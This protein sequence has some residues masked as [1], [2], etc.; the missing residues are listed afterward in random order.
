MSE[1]VPCK[2]PECSN[3]V[4]ASTAELN[5]GL[6]MICVRVVDQE[7]R[8]RY[9]R[10]HRRDVNEFEGV[11]DPVEALRIIHRPRGFDPLVNWIPN[12]TP[13][14]QL[15]AGLNRLDQ[16]R[17]AEYAESLIGTERNDEAQDI[18]LCLA[19]FT[20][21]PLDGCL[22]AFVSRGS[23]WPSMPFRRASEEL[24]DE[25][26]SML[27]RDG[28]N[29]NHVLMA[30]AWIG[31]AVVVR[32][33]AGWVGM[34]PSWRGCLFIPPQDYSRQ[35]GWEL[36]DDG[37]R[38]DLCLADCTKLAK[39]ISAA[40]ESFLAVTDANGV[41]P[42]CGRALVNLVDLATPQFDISGVVSPSGRVQVTTCE[43]CTAFGT[44]FG[45]F[46]EAGEGRWFPSNTRPQYLPDD[47]TD[48]T[49]LPRN[50]LTPVGMRPAFAAADQFLPTTFSQI[51]G[52]PTWIQD[53]TYPQC[54]VCSKTMMFLAQIAHDEIED[55]SE[56][57][58]Y[59][60]ICPACST[61]ATEYQQS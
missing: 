45:S 52:Y 4:L 17:L 5:D 2:N 41:C 40:P 57:V 20:D 55:Y 48:W 59:A 7:S 19:A 6:C 22:R 27:D 31:D 61:T 35:A 39:G 49:S 11:A 54:P 21:A 25:L 12:A 10:E 32:L 13:T 1:R 37:Q 51:G 16:Q 18:V 53:A 30:L 3:T 58:F 33:F 26:I 60:F 43:V 46:D 28:T 23:I 24:R 29:H 47:T 38:R 42:W 36:A 15:Y 14:D 34:P 44:V 50:S 9:I 8:A 56:G